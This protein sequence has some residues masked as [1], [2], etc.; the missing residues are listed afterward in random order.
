MMSEIMPQRGDLIMPFLSYAINNNKNKDAVKICEK[1]VKGLDSICD[2]ITANQ[3]LAR[4]NIVN[5]DVKKSI[6]LIKQ[7]ID[8]GIFNEIVY[9]FWINQDK[10][11]KHWGVKGIPLSPDILFLI[12]DKEK[13]EL[14]EIIKDKLMS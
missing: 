14:E 11:F 9:G 4:K 1:S 6:N 5:Q 10:E 8:K 12:S 13:S 7:A 2:L 3:I